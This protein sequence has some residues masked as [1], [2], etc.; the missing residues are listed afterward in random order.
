MNIREA[1]EASGMTPD[2]IRFYERKDVL[3]RSP[4]A[5]NGY[6]AYTE[7]HLATLRLTKSLR[8]LDLPL[9]EIGSIVAVAHDGTCGEL[10][11]ALID[12]LSEAV[13]EIDARI[14]GLT[15]TRD[16][17]RAILVGLRRMRAR[18]RRVPGLTRCACVR[19]V[20]GAE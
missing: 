20:A 9:A 1:A 4:R 17:L 16:E 12:R 8:D 14:E 6:R 7:E 3:P 11:G 5:A 13:S 19:L 2:T 18:E 10:R 15:R